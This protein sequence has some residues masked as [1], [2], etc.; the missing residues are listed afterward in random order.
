[1]KTKIKCAVS[2]IVTGCRPD[3]YDK[4]VEK[5]GSEANM[6]SSYVCS[7]AKRKLRAGQSV[8]DIRSESVA[9]GVD[10]NGLPS[11]DSLKSVVSALLG[12]TIKAEVTQDVKPNVKP[13]VSQ[14]NRSW[15]KFD[16]STAPSVPA[17]AA[18]KK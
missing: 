18:A 7:E 2:G 15:S 17:F 6:L 8:E 14:E 11:V 5:Y 16:N 4:R 12:E 9:S 3:V 10:I 13:Q 1:M